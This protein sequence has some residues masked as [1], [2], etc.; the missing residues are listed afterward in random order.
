[1]EVASCRVSDQLSGK[2]DVAESQ[3]Q[4]AKEDRMHQDLP[5]DRCYFWYSKHEWIFCQ[6]DWL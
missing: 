6:C 4:L 2:I 3:G 1:M 5:D